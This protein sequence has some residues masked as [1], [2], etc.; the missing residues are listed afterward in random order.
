MRTGFAAL[1]VLFVGCVSGAPARADVVFPGYFGGIV[2]D[3]SNTDSGP[4]NTS[5]TPG[6]V[7][8]GSFLYDA[9][10]DAFLSFQIGGYSAQ[11]GYT[12]IHSPKLASTPFAFI[13][14]ENPVNNAAPSNL[15][16]IN[17]NYETVPG[18]S[19]VNIAS[20]I[21]NPGPFSQ[22]TSDGS[23]SFFAVF[24]TNADGS[25]TQ[26]DALLT[27]YAAPEPASVLITLSALSGL[28]LMRRRGR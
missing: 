27:S 10:T 18:P 5:Y 17:F 11:P 24:L 13:G 19:T 15:L 22:N 3:G 2:D 16:Q 21:A 6:E 8:N 7:I 20:F 14:V 23:A 9:T 12:T 1:A 28:G 26:V 4:V 25:V